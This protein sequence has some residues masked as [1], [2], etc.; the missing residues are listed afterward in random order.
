MFR[1]LFGFSTTFSVNLPTFFTSWKFSSISLFLTKKEQWDSL[2]YLLVCVHTCCF[3][4]VVYDTKF[5]INAAVIQPSFPFFFSPCKRVG[6]HVDSSILLAV[7]VIGVLSSKDGDRCP[8]ISSCLLWWVY[9]YTLQACYRTHW[10]TSMFGISM[11]LQGTF[12]SL[13]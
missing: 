1:Q 11:K 13:R 12:F 10:L 6:P 9:F 5:T 4:L 8:L 7:W 3:S 2:G